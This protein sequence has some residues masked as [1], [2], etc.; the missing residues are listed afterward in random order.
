MGIAKIGLTGVVLALVLAV[1]VSTGEAIAAEVVAEASTG[2]EFPVDAGRG[3]TLLGVGV[4]KKLIIDVYASAIYVTP[5]EMKKQLKDVTP[6]SIYHALIYGAFPKR[7]VLHFVRSV[8]GDKIKAAFKTSLSKNLS[9]EDLEHEREVLEDFYKVCERGV[10]KGQKFIVDT[11]GRRVRITLGGKL[12]F[13]IK[14]KRL[15]RGMWMSW[16]GRHPIS[17]EM[18]KALI[19]RA[20]LVLKN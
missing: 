17:E 18:R 3:L 15:A 19:S 8:G 9:K 12:V 2:V 4:R 1:P 13:K 20:G 16:F 10:E 6:K 14:S 11:S 7:M 5:A